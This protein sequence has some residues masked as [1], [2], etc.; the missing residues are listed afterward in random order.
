MKRFELCE[1]IRER[2]TEFKDS[3]DAIIAL[4]DTRL[5]IW[6]HRPLRPYKS[7]MRS[8][9]YHIIDP[10]AQEPDLIKAINEAFPNQTIMVIGDII[11]DIWLPHTS[12]QGVEEKESKALADY[13]LGGAAIVAQTL[14]NL[15]AKCIL[16]SRIS[17]DT[18]PHGPFLEM[19]LNKANIPHQ[20]VKGGRHTPFKK[21][22]Y[23][24]TKQES[25][26]QLTDHSGIKTADPEPNYLDQAPSNN[27]VIQLEKDFLAI[28]RQN[29]NG[30]KHIIISDY[31][32]GLLT[33]SLVHEIFEDSKKAGIK[34]VVDPY[35]T[36]LY[37]YIDVYGLKAN[38]STAL[39]QENY[40]DTESLPKSKSVKAFA[41][42]T[43]SLNNA[44]TY[45]KGNERIVKSCCDDSFK[46]LNCRL[47]VF[48]RGAQGMFLYF[49]VEIDK[50]DK[51]F[52]TYLMTD[53]VKKA[54]AQD[55]V[56]AG[57]TAIAALTLCLASNF[58]VI[59]STLI[60]MLAANLKVNRQTLSLKSLADSIQSVHKKIF[61][62]YHQLLP[63][64]ADAKRSKQK[65]V[66]TNGVF[67]LCHPGHLSIF[68]KSCALGDILIVALNTDDSIRKL[69]KGAFRP[70]VNQTNRALMVGSLK[71]VTYVTFFGEDTPKK[72]INDLQPDI[73]VK[74]SDYA[75]VETD[76]M[77]AME[78]IRGS[79][80]FLPI[81]DG[82][83]TSAIADR[84]INDQFELH[85]PNT[86]YTIPTTMEPRRTE[87]RDLREE[88]TEML[89]P[90]E[91]NSRFF[92]SKE[93]LTE[94]LEALLELVSKKK[95]SNQQ[96]VAMSRLILSSTY[97]HFCW[98]SFVT[99]KPNL[100][101]WLSF[102]ERI[103]VCS[104]EPVHGTS[105]ANSTFAI[106]PSAHRSEKNTHEKS[107]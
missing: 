69:N 24:E 18:D 19:L 60:S 103:V 55:E 12:I 1:T 92:I 73:C 13:K 34:V 75:H 23:T 62:D 97:Q 93:S 64:I 43:T 57:D 50:K 101:T 46:K 78:A 98:S 11:L 37:N 44:P 58:T 68:E 6:I 40:K 28:F 30:V 15:Q 100:T 81:E 76:E 51:T 5:Q 82:Y 56:G 80:I 90:V 8:D 17:R 88:F 41:D 52:S 2:R 87:V 45:N 63:R 106:A 3:R 83:S 32:K 59:T 99:S 89:S 105:T 85:D 65:V 86:S 91:P 66:F 61:P 53:P 21:H 70:F 95:L 94:M 49:K 35:Y 27:D 48:T 84:V 31:E 77:K 16:L 9:V 72:I 104:N 22:Y 29:L 20:L 39:Y 96:Y 47:A 42:L 102:M 33:K 38:V 36:T 4:L 79:M 54:C 71:C 67:D 26:V 7:S 10:P 74:G 25:E 14:L 107:S